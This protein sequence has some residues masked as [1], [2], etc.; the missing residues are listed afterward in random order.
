MP[1]VRLA[2]AR[3]G[4]KGNISNIGVIAREP[5]F[6]PIILQQLTPASVKA[7]FA[8]LVSG[9]VVRYLVPGL[10]ACNF[11]LHDALDGGGMASMRLDPLGKGM[12]QMLLDMPIAVPPELA[13]RPGGALD[14]RPA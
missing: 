9:D 2:C 12:A 10:H 13:R 14:A 1:L 3:S 11:V 4:D 8:H 6:L 7:Y 5:E